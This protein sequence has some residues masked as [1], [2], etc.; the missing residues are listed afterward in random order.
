MNIKE[1]CKQ[2]RYDVAKHPKEQ[3]TL[4]VFT[5]APALF[6]AELTLYLSKQGLRNDQIVNIMGHID[7]L[8]DG[9]RFIILLPEK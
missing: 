2:A 6:F 1:F 3:N 5:S 4:V 7:L 8:P 9:D